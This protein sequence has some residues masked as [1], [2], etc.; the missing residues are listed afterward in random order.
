MST[1]CT[2]CV[3]KFFSVNRSFLYYS[4]LQRS[5]IL[6][7]SLSVLNKVLKMYIQKCVFVNLAL[8][9]QMG[10]LLVSVA[11]QSKEVLFSFYFTVYTNST[12]NIK[13]LLFI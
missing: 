4:L 8:G 7:V 6:N 11:G 10:Y 1:I 9:H 2:K 3:D 5:G 13:C 12:T